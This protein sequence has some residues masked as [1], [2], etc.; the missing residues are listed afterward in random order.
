RAGTLASDT[1]RLALTA[2]ETRNQGGLLQAATALTLDTQGQS[3]FNADSGESGGIRSQ[4]TLTV[5]SGTLDNQRGVMV[6]SDVARLATTDLNN[7][8]GQLTGHGGLSLTTHTLTNTS[9]R[10]QSDADLTINTQGYALDNADSGEQG[11]IVALKDLQ[12]CTGRLN[13][14]AGFIAASSSR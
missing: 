3:L 13:N 7:Q 14:Q 5:T 12:L 6:S 8:Q 10:L 1:G 2:G 9:G 11:G 4:G